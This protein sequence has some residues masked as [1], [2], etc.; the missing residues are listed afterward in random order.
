MENTANQDQQ[1]QSEVVEISETRL[2]AESQVKN[3]VIGSMG[4]SLVPV[5]L[6]DL[7][8]L[9]GIQIKMLYELAEIYE[10]PF[11]K[12]TVKSL[13]GAL[14][15]A[16]IPV[17]SASFVASLFKSIPGVGTAA[18]TMGMSI[19][20]GAATYAV[21]EVF[22]YHFESGGTFLD[23]Q[24]EKMKKYLNEQFDK[25]KEVAANLKEQLS[26]KKKAEEEEG[27]TQNTKT[28]A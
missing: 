16:I 26:S 3:Y 22:I 8:A 2:L 11:E 15:G 24:P 23:F 28:H 18:G 14:L 17:S 5:P 7:V 21:G 6:F 13:V 25:G 10:V 27:E 4:A 20:G 9:A 12:N 19:T 1:D